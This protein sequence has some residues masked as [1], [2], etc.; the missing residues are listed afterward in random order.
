MGS[1][2]CIWKC[3]CACRYMYICNACKMY[4]FAVWK[5]TFKALLSLTFKKYFPKCFCA[6]RKVHVGY[7]YHNTQVPR[8]WHVQSPVLL[9]HRRFRSS[10]GFPG[11][12]LIVIHAKRV[13]WGC[14]PRLPRCFCIRRPFVEHGCEA[15]G[16]LV[17]FVPFWFHWLNLYSWGRAGRWL[18][19]LRRAGLVL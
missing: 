17:F 13:V 7:D 18:G 12:H 1:W 16:R 11:R 3:C 19:L 10:S 15:H 2:M 9:V 8:V 14:L 5:S 6:L 4:I